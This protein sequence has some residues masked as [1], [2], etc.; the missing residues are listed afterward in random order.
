MCEVVK[1]YYHVVVFVANAVDL[2]EI[3]MDS[4]VAKVVL[5]IGKSS[6][7]PYVHL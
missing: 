1:S 6:C 3:E 2:S 5:H 7:R 4:Y